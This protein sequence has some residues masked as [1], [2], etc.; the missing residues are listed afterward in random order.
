MS[1]EIEEFKHEDF[2]NVR[3]IGDSDNPRFCLP[4]VC[5][6]LELDA[7]QV[8]RR[9]DST[10][11]SKHPADTGYGIKE[12][13]FI[14][15]DGLYDM[16]L[17]S[18]KPNAKKFRKWITSK[19]IPSIRKTGMYINP[20]EP[21][22]PDLLIKFG[23]DMKALMNQRDELK[24]LAAA[25]D[26]EIVKLKP[27]A[28]YC[29]E[30]LLSDEKLTSELIAKEY[31][32]RAHWLHENL[33]QLGIMYQ[34]GRTWYLKAPYDKAGYRVSETLTLERGKTVTNHY[35]TQKGRRFIYDTLKTALNIVPV[36]E[37][38]NPMA[39]LFEDV[40]A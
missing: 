9:L 37:R 1:T 35:W 28:E 13:N 40:T 15:E 6:V 33:K 38:E 22:N 8:A 27:D 23:N 5:K 18:R 29:R 16:I 3:V 24:L 14:N 21:I 36:K 10:V 30:V 11:F 31:G 4:D 34:R 25:K 26:E 32:E 20:N 39:N 2:G 19:V 12:V 17:D 7:S